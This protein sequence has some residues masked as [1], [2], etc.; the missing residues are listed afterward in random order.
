MPF[1]DT[2]YWE[3]FQ[4]GERDGEAWLS[5]Y[6][7]LADRLGHEIQ[8]L[9]RVQPDAEVERGL[10]RGAAHR[11]AG[12]ALSAGATR[13]GLAARALEHAAGSADC[14]TLQEHNATLRREAADAQQAIALFVTTLPGHPGTL[15]MIADGAD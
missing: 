11:L 15:H 1:D 4:P 13:L 8:H 9:L 14:A 2:M 3:M 12:A 10:L 7:E 5:E 6:Q